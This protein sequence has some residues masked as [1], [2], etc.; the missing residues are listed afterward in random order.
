M[1]INSCFPSTYLKAD[2][3]PA[4]R[5][6]SVTMAEVRL[7]PVD[8]ANA[9]PKPVLYFVGKKKGVVLNKVNSATIAQ[10]YGAETDHWH[11]RPLVLFTTTTQFQ[12]RVVPCLRCRVPAQSQ[13]PQQ[14][15]QGQS[16]PPETAAPAQSD[17]SGP[18]QEPPPAVD[19]SEIP[20]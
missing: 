5:E 20:F 2:D 7:E 14:P 12:G 18:A 4:G 3:I 9:D 11:G 17:F 19:D 6:V 8:G 1:D 15:P 13:A 16:V 10:V